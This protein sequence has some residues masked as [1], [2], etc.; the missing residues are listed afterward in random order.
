M[1][2]RRFCLGRHRKK[3]ESKRQLAGN[4][5]P[6]RPKKQQ[7]SQ[8]KPT[9]AAESTPSRQTE[10]A[11]KST[12]SQQSRSAAESTPSQQTRSAA[13]ST[14]SRQTRSAAGSMI[15]PPQPLMTLR[16]LY[17]SLPA[18][19]TQSWTAQYSHCKSYRPQLRAMYSR[20]SKKAAV[21]AKYTN[22]RYLNT[23]QKKR[24]LKELQVRAHTAE[25]EV[26]KLRER[27][28]QCAEQKGVQI[29]PSLNDDFL[30]I[31]TENNSQ[32]EK[33]FPEGSFRR[34]FWDQQFQ[35]AKTRDA[36]QMRWHPCM[37]RWCLNL[38]LLS[39]AAYHSL[40]TSGFL[41]LPSERTCTLR[42]YT[43]FIKSKA[44]FSSELDQLL[45]D[46]SQVSTLPEWKRHVV[47]VLDEMKVKESLVFDKQET[48]VVGFVDMGDVNNELADLERE[49]STADQHPTIA[50]HILVL[51]VRGVFTSW[52]ALPICS[53]P[54]H[55]E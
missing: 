27:I 14:P 40:R 38:K 34:L 30:A 11:A 42:D 10:S 31:M 33:H 52:H 35:A 55:D 16:M 48:E 7:Q 3:T 2:G 54:D 17:E 32:V 22:N 29:Q 13:D 28:E 19:V 51:M 9:T 24:K 47:L 5:K 37:I 50:T 49:C 25:K 53:L 12:P 21:S 8:T 36:R 41:K 26:K 45:A 39:S 15:P 20:W 4:N 46:E 44:G 43:H 6:G 23:P 18:P 1:G